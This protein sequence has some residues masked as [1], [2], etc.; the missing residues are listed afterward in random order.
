M[1][2]K[3]LTLLGIVLLTTGLA[4]GQNIATPV[5]VKVTN[6]PSQPVPTTVGPDTTVYQYQTVV[7][8][9]YYSPGNCGNNYTLIQQLSDN[10]TCNNANICQDVAIVFACLSTQGYQLISQANVATN[11]IVYTLRAPKH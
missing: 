5:P 11:Y 1:Q 3:G 7:G 8:Q 4:L 2:M 9:S 6:T 10:G